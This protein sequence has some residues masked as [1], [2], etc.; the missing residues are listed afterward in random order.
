MPAV[1]TASPSK[2]R[3]MRLIPKGSRQNAPLLLLPAV[4]LANQAGRPIHRQVGNRDCRQEA[5]TG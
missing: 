3:Q 4:A 1:Q 5:V 2:T